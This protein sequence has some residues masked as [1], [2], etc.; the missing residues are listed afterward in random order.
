M[1][2]ITLRDVTAVYNQKYVVVRHEEVAAGH[3]LLCLEAPE[4]ASLAVPGQFLHVRCSDG[5]DPILRRPLSIHYA[6]RDRGR[7]CILYRVLGRG[8]SLLARRKP[9]EHVDLMGPLGRGYTLPAAGEK[10]AVI[11]GGVGAAPL[12]F[13]LGEIKKICGREAGG[14]TVFL[15]APNKDLLPGAGQIREMGFPL[16]IATDDG[17]AG[18]KGTVV[19]LFVAAAGDKGYDRIYACGPLPMLRALA[20]V[21]GPKQ[22]AEASVEEHMGCG[23]GACLSCACKVRAGGGGGFRYAHV[24]TEGPVF[25]L[26][27][28]VL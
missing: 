1:V 12:F 13:L 8:T 23:V 3:R 9:G 16:E 10:V 6:D 25:N 24:C 17:S 27:E 18:L 28:L 21:V 7:V 20:G 2:L 26:R 19:D 14:V 4:I 22:E 5:L 15:G 11:G